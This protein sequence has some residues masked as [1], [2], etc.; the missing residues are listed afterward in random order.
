MSPARLRAVVV[1]FNAG[2]W[3]RRCVDALQ[4]ST[5]ALD[6]W[7]V[8][9]HSSDGSMDSLDGADVGIIL[10][11]TNRGFGAA[12]NQAAMGLGPEQA[13]VF[14]NPDCIVAPD[15]LAA[16]LAECDADA[17]VGLVGAWVLNRDGSLQK[18]TRRRLPTVMRTLN[19]LLGRRSA[20]LQDLSQLAADGG[21]VEAVSGA[22]MMMTASCFYSLG[23]FDEGYFLHCEDLDLMRRAGQAN[24]K[25]RLAQTAEATHVQGYSHRSGPIRAQA[26]KHASLVRY[27]ASELELVPMLIWSS[28]IWLHFALRLPL[29][30]LSALGSR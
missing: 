22:L 1:N 20:G 28:L 9:N 19:S 15:C 7:V 30:W 3:L 14:V 18:A 13:I 5:I 10:N 17:R 21:G 26:R 24:W 6:I 4:A 12:C 2:P 23:G 27:F 29:W 11:P 16:M 25:L 8:D